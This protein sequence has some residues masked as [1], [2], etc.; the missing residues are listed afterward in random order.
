MI[1]STVCVLCRGIITLLI[2][3][4]YTTIKDTCNSI[5][6][7]GSDDIGSLMAT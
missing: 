3:L 1:M 5:F 7:G 4:N 6:G 2:V